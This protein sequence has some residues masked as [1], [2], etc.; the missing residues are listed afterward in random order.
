MTLADKTLRGMIW[1]Q[2]VD[3]LIH[4]QS[5]LVSDPF[6]D[7]FRRIGH[8][9]QFLLLFSQCSTVNE[10][11][12][13]CQPRHLTIG[14][15]R[16]RLHGRHWWPLFHSDALRKSHWHSTLGTETKFNDLIIMPPPHR[17]GHNALMAVVCLSVCPMPDPKSRTEKR[18][19]LKIGKT[20]AQ[21]TGD[22]WPHSSSVNIVVC[23]LHDSISRSKG[24]RS[25]YQ[26][27]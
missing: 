19:K 26:A 10:F 7:G 8:S 11:H 17:V 18:R 16:P 24:Q 5:C 1:C 6:S 22:P 9:Y 20:E 3:A 27:A 12:C 25:R 2:T 14:G 23:W 21:D 15:Q 4:Q 13:T